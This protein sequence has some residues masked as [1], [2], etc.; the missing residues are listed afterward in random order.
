MEFQMR[1]TITLVLA[2]LGLLSALSALPR[3]LVVVEVVT[4]TWCQYCPG[5]AMA[6]HDL[7]ANGHPVAVIKN[8]TSDAFTN[9]YSEARNDFYNPTGVPTAWFDGLN[10]SSG[11]SATQ[12]LYATYLPRVTA[13]LG[14]PSHFTISAQGSQTGSQVQLAV[15]VAKPEADTNTNVKLHA[16]L[17]ES[18]IDFPWQNQSTLENVNRLMLP[19]QNGT[20]VNLDT[21]GSA[22]INLS[23]APDPSWQLANCEMVF[24]LQNMGSKEI[25]QAVKYELA[26][27]VGYYPIS[28][29]TLDFP[30]TYLSGAATLPLTITNYLDTPVSGTIASDD[31][32]FTCSVTNFNLPGASSLTATVTFTPVAV[33]T[34]TGNLNVTSNLH[35]HPNLSVI[36]SGTGYSTLAPTVANLMVTGPPVLYQ[37]QSASYDFLD[38]DGDAEGNTTYQWYRIENDVPLPIANANEIVYRAVNED[39]GYPIAIQVTP[40]DENGMAG[41]AVMSPATI[42]I[43]LL[44]PPQNLQASF[45]P[46]ATVSLSWELP[47][48]FGG[49]GLAGYR[50]FRGGLNHASIQ[51]PATLT[52]SDSNV[53]L[54]THEYWI[55]SLFNDPLMLS[56]PSNVVSVTVG[57]AADDQLAPVEVWVR[58]YPNP[59]HS[60]TGVSIKSEAGARVEFAIY[61]IRG[62]L[63]KSVNLTADN[64]GSAG[65]T[66]DGTDNQGSP[67]NSGVYQ[68]RMSSAGRLRSG[69]VVLMK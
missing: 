59:F 9:Q 41:T 46:P 57:V 29:N 63:V 22:T 69:R 43:E 44:P 32:A 2:L 20:I 34:Y 48:H 42:P 60:G 66:W 54:G 12:S 18:N 13:R 65:F 17:T 27:L 62:Q 53:S 61:N 14:V 36:L 5:A 55:C 3:E 35:N 15:T 1:K 11:G 6:C 24:F 49:R 45:I 7:L 30:D 33:Q 51:D 64:A 26:E 8:H 16:V 31:P 4:G 58:V 52:Y 19:D 23:F 38:A 10:A 37:Q 50:I 21:G 28:T 56:G 25:L 40:V 47:E 68:Y 67:V 39:L